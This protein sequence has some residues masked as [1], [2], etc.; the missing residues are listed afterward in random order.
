[1]RARL[2]GTGPSCWGSGEGPNPAFVGASLRPICLIHEDA[3]SQRDLCAY[4]T[5]PIAV[6]SIEVTRIWLAMKCSISTC[7]LPS[8]Q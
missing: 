1:M 2:S 5:P 8:W 7:G 3:W 6:G 4:K